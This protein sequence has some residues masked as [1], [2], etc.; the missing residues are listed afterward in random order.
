MS[1]TRIFVSLLIVAAAAASTPSA[2]QAQWYFNGYLGANHTQTADVNISQPASGTAFTYSQV[3]FE[4]RPFEAPQYYG[5]RFGH[6]QDGGRL[7]FEFEF[8]HEKVYAQVGQTFLVVGQAG[9]GPVS[10]MERM[11]AR[12]QEYA[13]SHGL[14]FILLNAVSRQP[15]GDNGSA[16]LLRG[17]IGP[18]L[19]HA[20]SIVGGASREQYEWAGVGLQASAGV[21]LH[22]TGRLSGLVEYKLTYAHPTISIVN[23]TGDM[24]AVSHHIAAGLGVRLTSR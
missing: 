21:D 12:V 11:D 14:N 17:G 13:M 20:E 19:P 22:M 15:I 9:G 10:G 4:S 18:T 6:I 1:L 5:Y 8:I 23:G 7:A 3:T 2:A 16:F 24:R